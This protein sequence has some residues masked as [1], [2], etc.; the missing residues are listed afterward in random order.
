[1]GLK[2]R[3]QKLCKRKGVTARQAEIDLDFGKG[4]ISKLNSSTPNA[5]KIQLMAEYFGTTFDYLMSGSE[6]EKAPTPK[7]ERSI[8]FDDFT[9]AMHNETKNLSQ[10]KKDMLLQMARFFN[11]ELE[12]EERGR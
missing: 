5:S 11:D 7:D 9:Y 12:K 3:V 10:E 1:M 8:T 2:E 6:A 4:Y